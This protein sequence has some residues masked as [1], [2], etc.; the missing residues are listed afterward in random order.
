MEWVVNY[1]V[2]G[3]FLEWI[4]VFLEDEIGWLGKVFNKMVNLLEI[5]DVKCKEFLVN[6]LYE[7]RIL[8]SYIK[9]YSEVI[10][11]GVVKGL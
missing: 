7:F 3:D 2:M 6:V 10:L 1:L 4:I 9:G 11:D 5:E 8:F